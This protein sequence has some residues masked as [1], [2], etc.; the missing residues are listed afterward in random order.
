MANTIYNE[1]IFLDATINAFTKTLAPLNSFSTDFAVDPSKKGTTVSVGLVS[2]P[3]AGAEFAG[4]Y[5]TGNNTITQVEVGL[6]HFFKSFEIGMTDNN[7]ASVSKLTNLAEVNA[8]ALAN[9]IFTEIFAV[10][11]S[12][13]YDIGHTG[14]SGTFT[15]PVMKTLR[16]LLDAKGAPMEGRALVI[17][18]AYEGNLIPVDASTLNADSVI[19]GRVKRLMGFDVFGSNYVPANAQNL[20][21]VALHKSA[22]AVATRIPHDLG[23]E[24]GAYITYE[25][26]E[27]PSLGINIAYKEWFS[28]KTGSLWGAYELLCGSAVGTDGAVLV[29]SAAP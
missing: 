16:G 14:A 5:E 22:I 23:A 2:A 8:S 7:K 28:T 27:V 26:V 21:G 29:R 11:L 1:D 4:D 25:V 9:S 13:N 18:H 17:D 15:L 3:A 12:T 10:A 19:E 20:R 6:K 24:K